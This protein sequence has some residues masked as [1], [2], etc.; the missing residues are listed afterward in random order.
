MN[1]HTANAFRYATIV[2]MGGFLFGL[3]AALI[4]GGVDLIKAEFQLT[5]EQLGTAVAAPALGVLLALPFAG[6]VCN[7]F[8]RKKAILTIAVLYLISAIA[9]AFAPNYWTLTA[10]RF[11]GG[12]GW[13]SI[14]LASMYIGEIAPP[15][16]RGKLVSMTQINIVVGLFGA[17]FITYLIHYLAGA[18]IEWVQALGVTPENSWRWMLGAEIP[19]C[20]LWMGL[21]LFI[22]ESPYWFVYRNRPDEAKQRLSKLMPA[23]EI[24]A[25]VSEIRESLQEDSQDR[26]SLS[27]LR[28]IFSKPMRL[29]FIIAITIAIAQ[30]SSGINAV[31]FYA[32]TIFKQLG[33]GTDAAFVQAIW[34][35]LTSVVFTIL[36]LLLV[37]KL[38]RRPL[39]IWGMVWII[40]SL[41]LCSYAFHEARYTLTEEAIAEFA[42]GVKE[43][44]S[45]SAEEGEVTEA[46]DIGRL[47]SLAGV[48]KESD[49]AFREALDESI[50]KEDTSK[51][52][53]PLLEAAIKIDAKLVLLGILSF[54]AAFHFSVGPV[55]WVLFSE[56]FPASVRGMAIPFF[57]IVTSLT[58]WLVQKFFPWQMENM[59]MSFTFLF[60]AGTVA[61]GLVILF[62]TL[63]ETKNMSI[64]EIQA[65]LTP[66]A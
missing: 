23:E 37:D 2:A 64:E 18:G 16:W 3:D 52:F 32:Q 46:F 22:P 8:G 39:I 53:N 26:S 63:K 62:F 7:R 54:I 30:Q 42:K 59:G 49:I 9:S 60:Y 57:A 11:L 40:A 25:H 10:A 41:G 14:S 36:G 65:A 43:A 29:I 15:K 58:S 20:L 61:I 24:E 1:D 45:K 55:M 66:D 56:I 12:V 4:S 13:S 31:L 19:I 6:Y 48:E 17:Y 51:Y 21:L 28:I 35:G 38:G 33:I 5:S 47:D 27:E 34:V 50:D 44:E